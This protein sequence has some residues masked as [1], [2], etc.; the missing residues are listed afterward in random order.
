MED[1]THDNIETLENEQIWSWTSWKACMIYANAIIGILLLEKALY[2]TKRHRQ[3]NTEV[4]KKYLPAFSRTDVHLWNRL[5]LYPGAMTIMVP[6]L[7]I[8]LSGLLLIAILVKIILLLSCSNSKK[9]FN[10]CI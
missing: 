7:I 10:S 3:A 8:V 1:P 5:W 2:N 4:F 6:R 9:P